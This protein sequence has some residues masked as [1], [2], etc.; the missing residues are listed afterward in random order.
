MQIEVVEK[1]YCNLDVH[2]EA[3]EEQIDNKRTEVLSLFKRA[4]VKGFRKGKA[5]L[6]A[7]KMFYKAQIEES[8]KRALAEEAY[9]NTLFEKN[10]KAY[11]A[12]DFKSILLQKDKF[13]CDFSMRKKPDF[14]LAEYK[15]LEVPKPAPDKDAVSLYEEIL[16]DVRVRFSEQVPFTEDDFVQTSDNVILNYKVYDG[17]AHLSDFDALGEMATVGKS[18]MPGFDDAILGMKAGETR[19][20]SLNVPVEGVLPSVAGKT[21]KFVVDLV[22]GSKINPAPLNDELAKKCNKKDFEELQSFLMSMATSKVSEI[23][24]AKLLN[25]V[26]NRLVADNNFEVPGWLQLAEA[27][28]LA[29]QANVDWNLT[30]DEVKKVYLDSA[31]K[32][33]KLSLILDKIRDA[34]PEAQLSDQETIEIIKGAL[35]KGSDEDI[36]DRLKQMNMSGYLPVL[37]ARVRDEHT[38]DFV[39]NNLKIVE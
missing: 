11:G 37:V 17:E 22:T 1:E 34:E 10:I 31:T 38:L 32:N 20:F 30:S 13:T 29:M 7:I 3:G 2:Y 28:T 24:K 18:R 35:S 12:P 15:G 19:E 26:S 9:H 33:V 4:P 16:Q 23:E 8:L 6:D 25:E 39:L 21:L 5:S 36:T 14:E 27:K